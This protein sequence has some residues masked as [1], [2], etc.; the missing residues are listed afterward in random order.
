MRHYFGKLEW[1]P[2]EHHHEMSDTFDPA[3]FSQTAQAIVSLDSTT[4]K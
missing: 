1:A 3:Y 4:S 2:T